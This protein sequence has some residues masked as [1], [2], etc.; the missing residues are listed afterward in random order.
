M[1]ED[2]GMVLAMRLKATAVGNTLVLEDDVTLPEG[3]A[4]EV[5]TGDE[6]VFI[7]DTTAIELAEA[8]QEA[9]AEEGVPAEEVFAGLP[10]RRRTV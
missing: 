1:G 7:D 3:T 9:D 2:A 8:M 5:L 6:G 4:V 10:P